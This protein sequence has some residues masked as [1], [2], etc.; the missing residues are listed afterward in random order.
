[1]QEQVE[2]STDRS[3]SINYQQPITLWR[4]NSLASVHKEEKKS[5]DKKNNR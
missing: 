5:I 1:M 2:L 3:H 4:A